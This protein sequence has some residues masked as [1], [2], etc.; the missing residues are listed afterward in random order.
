MSSIKRPLSQRNSFTAKT[1]LRNIATGIT[2]P[3]YVNVHESKNIG[4]HILEGNPV[5][6]YIMKEGPSCHYGYKINHQDPECIRSRNL[7]LSPALFESVTAIQLTTKS[8][9]ADSLWCYET[10]NLPGPSKTVLDGGALL[11][12]IPWT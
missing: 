10:E 6:S 3:P 4:K 5:A 11:H 8:S 7:S 12:R 1:S 9:L 2:A